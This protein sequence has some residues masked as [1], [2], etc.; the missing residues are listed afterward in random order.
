[1]STATATADEPGKPEPDFWH[2]SKGIKSWLLTLDHKRI[3]FMYL[4]GILGALILTSIILGG[5]DTG[6][7][8]YTPYS[9][10]TTSAVIPAVLGVFVL[11]FSSIFTGLNF[12]VTIHKFRPQGM[13]WF[14]MPLN[15]WAIYSTA[16][17]QVL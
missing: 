17:L 11:G 2:A 1:M 13:G 5:V 8:F 3:G 15:M 10:T 7:T 12:L 16:I 6:W 4:F 9:L 14:Q